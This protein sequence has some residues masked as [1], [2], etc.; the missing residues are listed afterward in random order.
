MTST[1]SKLHELL[2]LH[3]LRRCLSATNP[4]PDVLNLAMVDMLTEAAICDNRDALVEIAEFV[5]F[6]SDPDADDQAPAFDLR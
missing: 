4:R 5:R 1:D 6:Q 3:V 2:L